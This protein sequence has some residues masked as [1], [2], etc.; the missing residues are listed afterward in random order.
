MTS[1][2]GRLSRQN[3]LCGAESTCCV[4]RGDWLLFDA[5]SKYN[6]CTGAL[7]NH[8]T[9]TN[10]NCCSGQCCNR[11]KGSHAGHFDYTCGRC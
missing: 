4:Q 8:E 9:G 2:W 1:F 6:Y 11:E 5:D 7:K 3:W 10:K